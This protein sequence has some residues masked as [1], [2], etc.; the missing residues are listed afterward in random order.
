MTKVNEFNAIRI[1]LASPEQ[2]KSWSYGEVTKPE[3]INYRTLKPERD[4]LFCEKIFGP[5]KDWECYCGKYKKRRFQGVVCDKCQVEVQPSKVRRERMGHIDLAAPVA[6]IWFARGIPSR[7]GLVLDISPRNLDG[8]LNFAQYILISVDEE[9]KSKII[10]DLETTRHQELMTLETTAH[11]EIDALKTSAEEKG[12]ELEGK[13]K[14]EIASTEQVEPID[15]KPVKPVKTKPGKRKKDN[16]ALI[17]EG[18]VSSVAKGQRKLDEELEKEINKIRTRLEDEKDSKDT[19]YKEQIDEIKGIYPRSLLTEFRYHELRNKYDN[20]FKAGTGAEALLDILKGLNLDEKRQQLLKDIGSTSGQRRKKA[21]KVLRVVEAFRR[22][23]NKPEWMILT[24]LPVLP[25]ELR[26]M[27]Q[28]DGGRFATSDLNDLYRR[29]INRN[30]RLRRLL[31]LGAPE[32][33]INNE[34]RMLQEAVDALIDNG[35]RGRAVSSSGNHKLKSLSD[36][37][38]GKQGRF[39]QNLLGKRVDYSGRSVIVVGPELKLHQ[40]GL[41]RRMALELFKPFIMRK[42]VENNLAYNI[43]AAKRLVDKSKPEVWDILEEIKGR[44][45]LLNRAPTLHRLGIQAFE[46]VLIDGSAI[47]LHPL[48]CTAFNADF[49]GDQMAVHIP[50]SEESVREAREVLLSTCNMLLPSNGDP[51]VTPTLDIVLGCYYLTHMEPDG[52]SEP[53]SMANFEEAQLAYDLGVIGINEE[54]LVKDSKGNGEKLKTSV[55][56]IIFNEVLPPDVIFINGDVDKAEL[57]RIVAQCYKLL[58]NAGT[59]EVLDKIKTLGFHYATQSGITIGMHDLEVPKEKAK[60]MEQAEEEIAVLDSQWSKG[61]LEEEGLYRA[62]VNVWEDATQKTTEAI[63]KN[64]H[65]YG[66]VYVMSAAGAKGNIDQIRQMAGMRGLMTDPSGR[67]I[68]FPIKSSFVEGLTVME[69]FISTHGARK[70][71]ADTALRT[72]DSG[73]LTRRLVD[74]SQDVITLEQDC[75]TTGGL[76]I[77]EPREKGIFPAMSEKLT[78]RMA[79]E[80]VVDPKTGEVQ[81]ERNEEITEEKAREIVALGISRVLVRS[82]LGC[83]AKRGEDF[84]QG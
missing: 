30:N 28:L 51:V 78:G 21:S 43:K 34:K 39:R 3:T 26:P 58:G 16:S 2:I 83:L 59:A 61:L 50:L 33:I 13:E 9:A 31:E 49:D 12:Q 36:M 19:L 44:P 25:A 79:A 29:V 41:P 84:S 55:G 18:K 4:G 70:G 23:G 71:L 68:D 27:V 63:K 46:P 74:V 42:L 10:N 73:Y 64:L 76:W 11:Q 45:V 8:I 57:K 54:I 35:R 75:Q 17:E 47:Q 62:R 40:C 67:V 80:Q 1:A 37:L 53:R 56:R 24:R 48:V 60:I 72:S 81:L 52:K 15:M 66:G 82:P 20:L 14:V 6:H 5:T 7:I 38:R 32:I 69:Y 65:R 77:S 22:S